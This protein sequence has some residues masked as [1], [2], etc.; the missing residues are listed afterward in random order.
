MNDRDWLDKVATAADVY[1]RLPGSNEKEIDRFL[2]YLFK[3]YGYADL[4]EIR[5]IKKQ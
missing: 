4:L 3:V 5:K 1:C 2:E